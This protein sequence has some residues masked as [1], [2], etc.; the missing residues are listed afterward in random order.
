MSLFCFDL[1]YI[2]RDLS[3]IR[4]D[5]FY[6]LCFVIFF[7]TVQHIDPRYMQLLTFVKN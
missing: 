1:L 5:P 4:E 7:K 6:F 2:I 3:N